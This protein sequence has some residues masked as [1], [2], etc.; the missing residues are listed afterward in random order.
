MLHRATD[1][2]ADVSTERCFHRPSRHDQNEIPA[3]DRPFF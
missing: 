1:N 3:T 2:E